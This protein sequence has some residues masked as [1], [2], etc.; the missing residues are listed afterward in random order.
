[1]Y[2]FEDNLSLYNGEQKDGR[3]IRKCIYIINKQTAW[4]TFD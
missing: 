2:I 3:Y 1:M 4:V